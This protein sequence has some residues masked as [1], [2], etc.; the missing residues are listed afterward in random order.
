FTFPTADVR[1][2]LERYIAKNDAPGAIVATSVR[3]GPTTVV[4]TG[5]AD[6]RTMTPIHDDDVFRIA[7]VT[8]TF[9]GA[10]VLTLV[11]EGKVHLDD[12]IDRYGIDFPHASAITVRQLLNHTSGLAPEGSDRSSNDP[13]AAP[14]QALVARDL[15]HHFTEDE[16][17]A[18]VADRPLRF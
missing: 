8:K 17:L 15:T 10:L 2:L 13:E 1:G 12:T 9:V 5:V 18:Y 11:D 6:R 4:T 7:S 14:F 16:I 3:G